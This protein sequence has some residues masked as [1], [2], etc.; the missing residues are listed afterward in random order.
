MNGSVKING[1]KNEPNQLVN[2]KGLKIDSNGNNNGSLLVKNNDSTI[3]T[4]NES[5]N[6]NLNL[7]K[8][9]TEEGDSNGSDMEKEIDKIANEISPE[10]KELDKN[11]LNGRIFSYNLFSN[12]IKIIKKLKI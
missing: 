7:N 10:I 5:N 12:Y 9:M 1:N 3:K 6:E 4:G 2:N 8:K 11:N